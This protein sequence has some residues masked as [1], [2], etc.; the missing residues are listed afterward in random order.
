MLTKS[1]CFSLVTLRNR[2]NTNKV[3]EEKEKK[4]ERI[5]KGAL[6]AI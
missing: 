2:V 3:K 5:Q 1:K 6:P 4:H